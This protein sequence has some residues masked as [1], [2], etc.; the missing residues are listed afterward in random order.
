MIIQLQKTQEDEEISTKDMLF[1]HVLA[2]SSSGF[3]RFLI[4]LFTSSGKPSTILGRSFLIQSKGYSMMA[5]S[6]SIF[7][8]EAGGIFGTLA[9]GWGSDKIFK[10]RRAPV[11]VIFALGVIVAIAALYFSP[12]GF[13]VS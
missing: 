4:F 8:F 1:K 9:A 10:G 6:G 12:P 7:W 3:W 2:I 5:A 11:N 13:H